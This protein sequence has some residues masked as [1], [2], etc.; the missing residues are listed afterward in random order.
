MCWGLW[1][2]LKAECMFIYPF[3][4][5]LVLGVGIGVVDI[6]Y[7]KRLAHHLGARG[8]PSILGLINGRVTSFHNAVSQENLRHFMESLLPHKLVE[9]VRWKTCTLERKHKYVTCMTLEMLV[10]DIQSVLCWLRYHGSYYKCNIVIRLDML[11]E[12]VKYQT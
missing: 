7:E 9:K 4:S 2:F 11:L 1:V 8:A 12:I 5:S 3:C 10:W 6:G